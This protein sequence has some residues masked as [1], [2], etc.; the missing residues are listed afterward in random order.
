MIYKPRHTNGGWLGLLMGLSLFS[1]II[2]GIDFSL[3]DNDSMLRILLYVPTFMFMLI[4]L[5]ILFGAF[6]LSY[7]IEPNDLIITWGLSKKRISYEQINEIV[8][9]KGPANILPFLG[10][11]WR[12][13]TVGLFSILGLGQVRM[14]ATHCKEEFVLLKTQNGFF[15]ITPADYEFTNVLLEKSNNQLQ[16]LDM[17]KLSTVE[18]GEYLVHDRFFNLLYK[19]NILFLVTFAVFLGIFFPGSGAPELLILLL[20]LSLIIFIFMASNAK[21]LYQF[22]NQGSYITLGMGLLVTGTL[23]LLSIF[24]IIM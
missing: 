18:K 5:Y 6:N 1:F 20:V 19:S 14:Y 15:G 2:W 16:I 4:Y 12:G 23:I 13:Y 24:G 11:D 3:N 10:V 17:D 7:R 8:Q 9:I 21:R 22:S